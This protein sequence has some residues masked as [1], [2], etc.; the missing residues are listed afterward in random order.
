MKS[1][2]FVFLILI[3]SLSFLYSQN[4]KIQLIKEMEGDISGLFILP[5]FKKVGD[6]SILTILPNKIIWF[7]PSFYYDLNLIIKDSLY[8]YYCNNGR[9][10]AK[11]APFPIHLSPHVKWVGKYNN[12]DDI[13]FINTGDYE[14]D[15]I[16]ILVIIRDRYDQEDIIFRRLDGMY[17][18]KYFG[19]ATEP[20][21]LYITP[22][23]YDR[24]FLCSYEYDYDFNV[25]IKDTLGEIIPETTSG[26]YPPRF[27]G[28]IK[29]WLIWRIVNKKY[30]LGIPFV[31][32]NKYNKNIKILKSI[33]VTAEVVDYCVDLEMF[34][35]YRHARYIL[36]EK[37][38]DDV[39]LIP[40]DTLYNIYSFPL[41]T[42]KNYNIWGL[43]SYDGGRMW[44]EAIWEKNKIII[45]EKRAELNE[46][47]TWFSAQQLY[48]LDTLYYSLVT[49]RGGKFISKIYKMWIDS[50]ITSVFD[51]FSPSDFALYQN[52]P[53]PFNPSTTIEFDI[54]ERIN[55]KLI[56][57]DILGR[58]VE[59]LI[60]KELEPGKYKLNFNA[61]NLPSGV[62]FY[63]LRTP[64]FTKTN[65]MLL[66]K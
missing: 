55:V 30:E 31:F 45:W 13:L 24:F 62:Y 61:T 6:D 56:I 32:V 16:F 23:T 25:V 43:I 65:K 15:D 27:L 1:K 7:A 26:W 18:W 39:E 66:I 57:Y 11:R 10:I 38:N 58:E 9:V 47:A 5:S 53:N 54:P 50:T 4:F 63:T 42:I 34:N 17:Y 49:K 22:L 46:T 48:L 12:G 52:Y 40:Y 2:Y 59:T 51:N 8:I 21:F 41:G 28:E 37:N 3:L 29:N 33:P 35:P 44:I 19:I 20:F 64:K 60:D 36:K 14:L